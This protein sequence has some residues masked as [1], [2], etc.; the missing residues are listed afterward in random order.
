MQK[1]D[2]NITITT[3]SQFSGKPSIPISGRQSFP[4]NKV[5]TH[6]HHQR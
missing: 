4:E 5:K 3:V 2:N 6:H 1:H